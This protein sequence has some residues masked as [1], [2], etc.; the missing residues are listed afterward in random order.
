MLFLRSL[1][2]LSPAKATIKNRRV[3]RQ[4]SQRQ[5]F[6]AKTTSIVGAVKDKFSAWLSKQH[7]GHKFKSVSVDTMT[8]VRV[9]LNS[10]HDE[11]L[12]TD[13]VL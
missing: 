10:R 7:E 3:A 8:P 2:S 12:S 5:G 6:I 13:C 9:L 1:D 11:N 4:A